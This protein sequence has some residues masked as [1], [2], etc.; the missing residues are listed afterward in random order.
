LLGGDAVKRGAVVAA[1]SNAWMRA[2]LLVGVV[3]QSTSSADRARPDGRLHARSV[4][5]FSGLQPLFGW[6]LHGKPRGA[7]LFFARTSSNPPR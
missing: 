7:S 6:R 2:P 5:D 4:A 1:A 3:H